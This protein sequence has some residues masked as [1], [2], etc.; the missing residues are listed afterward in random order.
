MVLGGL[1]WSV[2]LRRMK[3]AQ[4]KEFRVIAEDI[5]TPMLHVM[6]YIEGAVNIGLKLVHMRGVDFFGCEFKGTY[7]RWYVEMVEWARQGRHIMKYLARPAFVKKL[8]KGQYNAAVGLMRL[9]RTMPKPQPLTNKQLAMQFSRLYRSWVEMNSWGSIIQI[10]DF[11]L[12]YVTDKCLAILRSRIGENVQQSD[13]ALCFGTLTTPRKKTPVQQY[14][15][16]FYR[17]L[18]TIQAYRGAPI[19]RGTTEQIAKRLQHIPVLQKAVRRL[20]RAYDWLQFHYFGPTIL[21]DAYFITSLRDADKSGIQ[22]SKELSKLL[23]E[24]RKVHERA[25]AITRELRLTNEEQHW[26]RVARILGFAKGLRKDAVFYASRHADSLISEI[27]RRL[28]LSSMQV[29]YMLPDEIIAALRGRQT[30][31]DHYNSRMQHCVA[32]TKKRKLVYLVGSEARRFAKKFAVVQVDKRIKKFVGDPAYPGRKRGIVRIVKGADDM[33]KVKPG[34]ILVSPATNPNIVPAMK[35]A[36]AFVT[37]EGGVTCHAAIMAR[38]MRKPCV[39]GTKIATRLL[40]D[41]DR[42]EV[43]ADKGIIQRITNVKKR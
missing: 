28:L 2:R 18:A 13:V 36:G 15:R 24:D 38:E 42:V 10:P 35:R 19:L 32:T 33:P 14:D 8:E 29:R 20:V 23:A 30:N 26:M 37:D 25:K 22:G 21:D 16:D 34:D 31:V 1:T 41:G 5:A 11:E 4:K 43:D 40:K 7:A 17:T 3:S 39:I 12:N 9:V 27:A 6:A